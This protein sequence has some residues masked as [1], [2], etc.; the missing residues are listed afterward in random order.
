[1]S[2]IFERLCAIRHL[3]PDFLNPKYEKLI[4]PFTLTD[5][6]KAVSRVKKAIKENEKILIYG[7]YDVDGVTAN[8]VMEQ[9]LILAGI[10]PENI[11]IMLPDRFA[12]GYGMSPKLI[13]RAQ[14]EDVTLVI[15]V[16]CG[17]H[18]HDIV[19]KLNILNIDSIITDHHETTNQIPEAIAVINPH[20][21]D[22]PTVELQNL[23]GVGVAF[24]FAE[25]LVKEH[26]IKSGQE[27]W[28][29]DLVLLG[30]ICDSMTLTGE[31][32]RLGYY[33]IKVLSK[34]RRAGLKE[35]MQRAGVKNLNSESIG[36]QIG[37]RL[38]SAGRL[39][40]ADIS[41]NLLRAKSS[42]E[43][44]PFAEKLEQ[45]NK[46]R[47]T[48]QISATRE[49]KERGESNDPVIIET[50]H[51]HEGI[52]GIVAG[53]L[54]E[55][56]HKPAF[57]LTELEN[58]IFKGSGRSF[59]DFN[60]AEALDFIKDIIIGGGGHAGAAGV[61]LEQKNLYL[62]RE[63]INAYYQ[64]LNLK[65]QEK[66]F[67]PSA[68]LIVEDFSELNLDFLKELKQLEPF[69]PGNEEPIFHLKNVSITN[70]TRMGSELN[71]LRLDLCDHSGKILKCLAFFAPK[72]WF[73]I[74]PEY[75][76]VELFVKFVEND[77]NGVKSL[78]ARIIDII[79]PST[80]ESV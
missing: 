25:A 31:N 3:D 1:M 30:T 33:G 55:D 76:H 63:K 75:D 41:L 19:N 17:S 48:E 15:T 5:M 32:R 24:K 6:D 57:V 27:K 80:L 49:I 64:N 12:D 69:G 74:N 71:H 37:P 35:L 70:I 40:S 8:T 72:N 46:K 26:L 22:A 73:N 58:G 11:N 61:R 79:D 54:V 67:N 43:A 34:T 23:A 78:E 51:W 21:K 52:L 42:I 13:K 59:G 16:D 53:R 4:D 7:D 56:Y 66:F 47:K 60:L 28:L 44:A 20:R 2:K 10:K 38:N 68:D 77:F 45:L 29:L 14:K 39:E 18:N 50:G 62:F 36:F 9:T 65:N